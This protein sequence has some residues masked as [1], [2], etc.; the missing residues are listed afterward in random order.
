MGKDKL[1][2]QINWAEIGQN[3]LIDQFCRKLGKKEDFLNQGESHIISV[4]GP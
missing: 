2:K 3:L 4:G 1:R